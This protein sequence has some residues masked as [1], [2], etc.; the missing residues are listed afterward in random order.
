MVIKMTMIAITTISS[1]NVKPRWPPPT[2]RFFRIAELKYLFN[3]HRCLPRSFCYIEFAYQSEYFVPSDAVPDDLL[4]T[5]NTSCPPQPVESASSC[6]DRKPQSLFFV[7]GS[8][9]TSRKKRIRLSV[10]PVIG[11]GFTSVSRSGGYPSVPA[12]T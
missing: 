10:L 4:Y 7:R 2:S 1:I 8:S 12:F 3:I 6:T 9:G 11:V 5:S